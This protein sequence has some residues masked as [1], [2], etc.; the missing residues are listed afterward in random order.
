VTLQL[1]NAA[2]KELT[3]FTASDVFVVWQ[4]SV[5]VFVLRILFHVR[6]RLI[7]CVHLITNMLDLLL[8]RE[9]RD[10]KTYEYLDDSHESS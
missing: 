3:D 8:G 7:P 9:V 5:E 6:V 1:R 2:A 10:E 4:S